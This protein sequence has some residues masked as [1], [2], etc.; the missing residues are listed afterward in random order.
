LEYGVIEESGDGGEERAAI[1]GDAVA[2]SA[3]DLL[4]DALCRSRRS[5]RDSLAVSEE[6]GVSAF[7][8]SVLRALADTSSATA[9]AR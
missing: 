4:D 1:P 8:S 7:P 2:M 5:R 3:C 9:P 6:H